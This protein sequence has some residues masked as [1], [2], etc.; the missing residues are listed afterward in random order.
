MRSETRE[1]N[2]QIPKR[3]STIWGKI[4]NFAINGSARRLKLNSASP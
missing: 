3:A 1:T 4:G 2:P